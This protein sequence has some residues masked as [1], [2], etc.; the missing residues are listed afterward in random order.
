MSTQLFRQYKFRN[1]GTAAQDAPDG[2]NFSTNDTVIGLH[3]CNVHAN[4]IQA[5]VYVSN[6]SNNYY[7]I[8]DVNIP[9]GASLQ[10]LDGGAK[11]NVVSGDR[12]WIISNTASSL[13]A[14]VSVVQA[15]SS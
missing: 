14:F 6:N 15:I 2:S 7:I 10:V 8:K 9:S 1:I 5:S 11:M 13:D 4:Q 3:L 12:L